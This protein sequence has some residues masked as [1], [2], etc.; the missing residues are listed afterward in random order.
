MNFVRNYFELIGIK[1]I[2]SGVSQKD[3]QAYKKDLEGRQE[4][5]I[6]LCSTDDQYENLIQILGD[7]QR[8]FKFIAGKVEVPGF[9]NLFA[10]QN[11]Y[12]VLLDLV[13]ALPG[14]E[15]K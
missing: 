2:D 4:E 1:V 9:K 3:P 11:V 12:N 15:S 8:R 5:I 6:V 14:G 13:K 10:G 7:H